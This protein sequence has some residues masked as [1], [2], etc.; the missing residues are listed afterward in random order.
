LNLRK[1]SINN[2]ASLCRTPTVKG[3]PSFYTG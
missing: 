3:N 2:Y 1:N